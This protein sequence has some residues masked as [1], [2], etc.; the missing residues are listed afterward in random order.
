MPTFEKDTLRVGTVVKN[1][2]KFV[3]DR[4]RLERYAR[5]TNELIGSEGLRIPLVYEHTDPADKSGKEGPREKAA[6]SVKN[7]AGWITGA[8]VEGDV[9][10]LKY[11]VPN[12]DDAA[13][14]SDG[15]IK[16][17]SPDLRSA[18]T[19]PSSGKT[20][21]D[22]IY[23]VA[24]THHPAGAQDD[25]FVQLGEVLQLSLADYEDAQL[26]E[27]DEEKPVGSSSD[28]SDADPAPD[29]S[30]NKDNDPDMP[31][32]ESESDGD[33]K[34]KLCL[35]WL[36]KL[37]IPMQS[38]TTT[39]N[40][41]DRL[42]TSLMA[43]SATIDKMESEESAED[44]DDEADDLPTKEEQPDSMMQFSDNPAFQRLQAAHRAHDEKR[45]KTLARQGRIGKKLA[46]KL[47]SQAG[48][49]QLSDD[50]QTERPSMSLDDVLDLIEGGTVDLTKDN[51]AQLSEQNHP[52][53]NWYSGTDPETG[54]LDGESEED[55]RRRIFQMAQQDVRRAG[56][57]AAK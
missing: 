47:L 17:V 44:Q 42:T 7:G 22:V 29:P 32:D 35:A 6:K 23:N 38:D 14:M 20:Y 31:P 41:V 1:G 40:F 9:L 11:D 54:R 27:D 52:R 4:N 3:F 55:E 56:F 25:G 13:K 2:R 45:I 53:S 36:D 57:A 8:R 50:F 26:A 16:F 5:N 24:L 51:T 19:S 34:L 15:R 37:D 28:E 33:K 49:V 43:V 48:S 21:E 30:D 10:K 18:W 12:K 46:E 39:E